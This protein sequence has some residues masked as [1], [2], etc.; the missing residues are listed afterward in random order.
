MTRTSG[1]SPKIPMN[2]LLTNTLLTGAK[3]NGGKA[4]I[5][6]ERTAHF[7]GASALP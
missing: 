5:I 1:I 4:Q 3:G 7:H 6:D 2:H